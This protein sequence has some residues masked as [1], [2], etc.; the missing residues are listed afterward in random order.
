[1]V[2]SKTQSVNFNLNEKSKNSFSKNLIIK[3][4]EM[5]NIQFD[6]KDK[7]VLKDLNFSLM[8]VK[9]LALLEKVELESRHF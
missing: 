9:K 1:M 7:K 4:F 8:Q 2:Y 3:N 6:F 5:K